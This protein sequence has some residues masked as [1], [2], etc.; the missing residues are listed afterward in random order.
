M[1]AR[2][3][4]DGSMVLLGSGD[5]YNA[6]NLTWLGSMPGDFADA[7]WLDAESIVAVRSNGANARVERRDGNGKVVEAVEFG[8][9]PMANPVGRAGRDFDAVVAGS[10]MVMALQILTMHSRWIPLLR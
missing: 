8:G 2:L 6:S 9:A 3:D 7:Q 1:K 10:L 5:V 4:P